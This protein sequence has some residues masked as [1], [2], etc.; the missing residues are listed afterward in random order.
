MW[1][2]VYILLVCLLALSAVHPGRLAAS[3]FPQIA[4]PLISALLPE[5]GPEKPQPGAQQPDSLRSHDPYTLGPKP[6]SVWKYQVD[7]S[8]ILVPDVSPSAD[9]SSACMR[10]FKSIM[11][12]FMELYR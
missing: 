7:H 8:E 9:S 11:G 10:V 4:K 6:F 2:P 1:R 5:P 3:Q 12:I